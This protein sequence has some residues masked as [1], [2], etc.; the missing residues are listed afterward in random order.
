MA[1][2]VT[3]KKEIAFAI[4]MST[5]VLMI[6]SIPASISF[7]TAKAQTTAPIPR[8][9]TPAV[10]NL[11]KTLN[12]SSTANIM[13]I[14]KISS[15]K[16]LPKPVVPT[17]VKKP[18]QADVLLTKVDNRRYSLLK[19]T[20]KF[21]I[22][23]SDISNPK[24]VYTL[25]KSMIAKP[26]KSLNTTNTTAGV[27]PAAFESPGQ[28]PLVKPV[29]LTQQANVQSKVG[30]RPENVSV[31]PGW[32]GLNSDAPNTCSCTPLDT[33][34][35]VDQKYV[36]EMVNIAGEIW[37]K[38]GAPI[39][40]FD[41]HSFFGT[42]SSDFLSDPYIKYD[43]ISGHWWATIMDTP[44][45]GGQML[46]LIAVSQTGDPTL[47][48]NIYALTPSEPLLDQPFSATNGHGLFV[49]SGNG[50]DANGNF[51][52][53]DTYILDWN[54]MATGSPT[55]ASFKTG[56]NGNQF[57]IHPATNLSPN[58]VVYA[59]SVQALGGVNSLTLLT[60]SGSAGAPMI[61]STDFPIQTTS[62]P[63]QAPE[64]GGATLN[65]NDG[66]MSD[67]FFQNGV[68][69]SGFNDGC[70]PAGTS[71]PHSCIRLDQI[72][73]RTN[74]VLQDFDVSV[75][76]GDFYF[77]AM[78]ADASGNLIFTFGYT[79]AVDGV[80]PSM[81][82]GDQN[83]ISTPPNKIDTPVYAA[84]GSVPDTSGRYGDYWGAAA[85]PADPSKAWLIGEYNI[86]PSGMSTF[87]GSASH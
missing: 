39:Q 22:R 83:A 79:S 28:V 72:N 77:P 75:A 46:L 25:T 62:L 65:T 84:V 13:L 21:N 69:W 74:Q 48:W 63:P 60:I 57:S 12:A 38:A 45:T 54:A 33:N 78:T 71:A 11:A 31:N 52:G 64:P 27:R 40:E 29:E 24:L 15:I 68:I 20:A 66:R 35:A 23:L 37:T 50:F 34:G 59:T 6:L 32:P 42:N 49:I 2:K 44:P 9:F 10:K 36:I 76:N 16:T 58:P 61:S 81:L 55:V 80:F 43:V 70:T 51:I 87:I 7:R 4:L 19:S 30:N 26:P 73:P 3:A 17:A 85:D 5:L 82:D 67:A 1:R 18:K 8:Q 56:A 53:A 47:G 41:L 86:S 14:K